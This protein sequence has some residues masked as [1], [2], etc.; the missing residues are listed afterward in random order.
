MGLFNNL[1]GKKDTKQKEVSIQDEASPVLI[2]MLSRYMGFLL[3]FFIMFS[4]H[5]VKTDIG[6]SNHRSLGNAILLAMV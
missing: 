1:K 2:D 3:L 4:F 6:K 5:I